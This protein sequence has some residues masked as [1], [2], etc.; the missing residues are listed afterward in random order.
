M[1]FF[2][3]KINSV[4]RWFRIRLYHQYSVADFYR[5]TF[6]V[7]IGSN[8]RIMD[9][10]LNL[11]GSEPY[12]IKIGNS[13]TLAE[14]V[15]LITHDGGVGVLRGRYPNINIYGRI[16]IN[17]NCFIGVNCI[18]LPGVTIGPNSVVGAGSVV[19]KDV[20]PN[21]VVAGVP[22]REICSVDEYMDKA[23]RKGIQ[24]TTTSEKSKRA[25]IEAFLSD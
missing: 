14:D 2:V 5:K 6:N 18:I 10:R 17:D 11:F 24:L 15:K 9:R 3:N 1:K 20:A 13:V 23:L 22:A 25:E 4:I 21:C 19:T 7:E 16:C 8:C 12:L